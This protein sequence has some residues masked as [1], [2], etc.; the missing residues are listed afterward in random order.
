MQV[1]AE[2]RVRQG[3]ALAAG[4]ALILSFPV[5]AAQPDAGAILVVAGHDVP[6]ADF[7]LGNEVTMAEYRD[8]GSSQNHVRKIPGM[9][10][11]GHMTVTLSASA[12]ASLKS[13]AGTA[14]QTWDIQLAGAQWALSEARIGAV[15]TPKGGGNSVVH[16]TYTS[17]TTGD[18]AAETAPAGFSG[19]LTVDGKPIGF[20]SYTGQGSQPLV[21]DFQ[22][23]VD[24]SGV[25]SPHMRDQAPFDADLSFGGTTEHLHDVRVARLESA[26]LKTGA[27][28]VAFESLE[29][30]ADA[31]PPAP[32]IAIDGLFTTGRDRHDVEDC[33]DFTLPR[34]KTFYLDDCDPAHAET[35][36]FAEGTAA[37][38]K[39]DGS[40]LRIAYALD[41]I[42]SEVPVPEAQAVLDEYA[43]LLKQKGWTIVN[44]DALSVTAKSGANWLEV[45]VN[46]GANYQIVYVNP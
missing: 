9:V 21:L 31:G 10:R 36:V 6:L 7:D 11:G 41:N 35:F 29:L 14:P 32:H 39:V 30:V 23:L 22:D 26:P 46:G 20:S 33:K 2:A 38:H 24:G 8:G 45:S 27:A 4:L 12:L 44:S 28:E 1:F 40:K 34:L 17:M 18:D 43:A 5:I 13:L 25:L 3:T 19:I 16:V 15:D 37:E 42:D